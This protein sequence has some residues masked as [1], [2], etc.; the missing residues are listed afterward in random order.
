[1]F[2]QFYD[3][4]L[5]P[6]TGFGRYFADS[7]YTVGA[8]TLGYAL[9]ML[10]RPV[11]VRRPATSGERTRAKA[12]VEAYGRSSLARMTLFEDKSYYFSPGGSVVA[13]VAKGQAATALGD[14]IGPPED[15]TAV[16][17][18]FRDYCA[19]NDW[20]PAFWSV[21]PDYLQ[22]YQAAGFNWLTIG[23]EGILDLA[24]FSL[25]GSRKSLRSAIN[26]LT[27]SGYYTQI[28]QPPLSD[29]VM[30]ELKTISD[31]WLT[32][33]H[34]RE[35][36]FSL[37]WFEDTYIR[38]AP[39]IAV[40]TPEGVISAFANVVP[41]YQCNEVT[42]DLIRRRANIE[43]GTMD[44]LFISFFEWAKAQGYATFNLGLSPLA[45]VG[46]QPDDP[47]VE[48]A[49]RFI[50]QHVNQFYNFKGLHEFKEKFHPIW[51]SR[52]LIYPG[53]VSLPAIVLTLNR[54]SSGDDFVWDYFKDFVEKRFRVSR[55]DVPLQH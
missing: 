46:E 49:L 23:R 20:Q 9:L 34:G 31:E 25:S 12:I 33:M 29:E 24:S 1:M 4:G 54:A 50:Y 7:I 48:K 36:R 32:L 17:I 45:G 44:F 35:K 19:K 51:S 6:L 47:A 16:I 26:K 30:A 3:P 37:G 42:T 38:N 53:P 27:R 5:Q 43:N 55:Q 39:V 8:V 22:Y 28:H 15:A 11:L 40:H 13:Y 14:P 2:T 10:I 52:Y 18:E 41:E 21:Q